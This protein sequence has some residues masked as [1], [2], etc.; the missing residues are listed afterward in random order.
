[1]GSTVKSDY[2]TRTYIASSTWLQICKLE[3]KNQ[4]P[5]DFTSLVNFSEIESEILNQPTILDGS[6]VTSAD[7]TKK[8][9]RFRLFAHHVAA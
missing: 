3:N 9:F 7:S 8:D 5:S 2:H 1:M 4:K 6:G